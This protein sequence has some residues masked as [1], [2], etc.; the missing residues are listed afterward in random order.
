SLTAPLALAQATVESDS[1]TLCSAASATGR[2]LGTLQKGDRAIIDFKMA[3]AAG[4]W[5]SVTRLQ[6]RSGGYVDCTGLKEPPPPP[7]PVGDHRTP[8]PGV[9]LSARGQ[10]D[11]N[12]IL[13]MARLGARLSASFITGF[14]DQLSSRASPEQLQDAVMIVQRIAKP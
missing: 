8:P 14:R 2:I 9:H 13:G 5:C 1:L 11:I 6:T 3:N 10:A 12:Q 4:N 7:L